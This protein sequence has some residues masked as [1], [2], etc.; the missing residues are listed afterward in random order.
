MGFVISTSDLS[1]VRKDNHVLQASEALRAA[2]SE[3]QRKEE[4]SGVAYFSNACRAYMGSAQEVYYRLWE[5]L[6]KP[7]ID[8]FGE[9]AFHGREGLNATPIQKADALNE[10]AN[11][12]AEKAMRVWE[13]AV[14]VKAPDGRCVPVYESCREMH[15]SD[16]PISTLYDGQRRWEAKNDFN[17]SEYGYIWVDGIWV[18]ARDTQYIAKVKDDKARREQCTLL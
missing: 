16:T 8:R 2:A 15:E 5:A 17:Y 7:N 1:L 12:I 18:D 6:G 3:Y 11:A 10:S 4:L 14:N 9:L 13:G